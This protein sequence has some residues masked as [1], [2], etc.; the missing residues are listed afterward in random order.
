MPDL[1]DAKEVAQTVTAQEIID[2]AQM[3]ERMAICDFLNGQAFQFDSQ[4]MDTIMLLRAAIK[5]GAHR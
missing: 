5:A 1:T 4:H 2:A 3:R